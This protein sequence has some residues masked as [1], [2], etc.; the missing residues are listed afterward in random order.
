[1]DNKKK[2]DKEIKVNKENFYNADRLGENTDAEFANEF[3]KKDT[4][5]AKKT[6]K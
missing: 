4:N 5:K 2:N 1:M 3:L 6:D